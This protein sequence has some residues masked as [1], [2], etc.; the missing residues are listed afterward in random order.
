M[1]RQ[2]IDGERER[3]TARRR[4][5]QGR[6]HRRLRGARQGHRPGRRLL[7]RGVLRRE[8]RDAARA[9]PSSCRASATWAPT[10][11]EILA[12]MGAQLL[13]VNDADG[14]IYNPDGIDVA[15]AHRL[16]LREP[17]EPQ[18]E[19]R[20]LPGRPADREE[21][22]LGGRGRHLHPR[23]AGRRDHRR[24]RRA[25]QGEAGGRGRQ[26]PHHARG[27]PGAAEAQ[28]RPHPGHH[29]Q[30]RRRDGQLLRVAPEQAHGALDRGGGERRLERA[31][32]RNYRII[33]DIARN[34]PRRTDM[35]DSRRYCVGKEVDPRLAAM[36]L[37]LKRIEA[38]YLLEGF[39][40]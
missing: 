6:A 16:R 32:K 11:A 15:G 31:I 26:R 35:H 18:A 33:R 17:E 13:A 7:H 38:H 27:R 21:G 23:R 14:T 12:G 24:G 36:V 4:H 29:R 22:L 19:R 3:H 5:R 10:R 30:R 37:A 1:M 20:R 9:R 28:D 39:S 34:R 8:G 2:Y 25:A 40:K